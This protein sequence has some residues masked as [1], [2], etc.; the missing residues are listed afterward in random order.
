M[1]SAGCAQLPLPATLNARP[2]TLK[3]SLVALFLAIPE[4]MGTKS[5]A[6]KGLV[7]R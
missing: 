7:V 1:R 6:K 2:D 4:K 3:P 5:M